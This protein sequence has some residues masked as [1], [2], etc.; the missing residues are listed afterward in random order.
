L[1]QRQL[2]LQLDAW[3]AFMENTPAEAD[4]MRQVAETA[5]R[6]GRATI[7]ELLDAHNAHLSAQELGLTLRAEAL[8]AAAVLEW[9]VGPNSAL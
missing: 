4:K 6:E 7:L 1:A 9:A 2:T 5:Y 8:R 3:Q